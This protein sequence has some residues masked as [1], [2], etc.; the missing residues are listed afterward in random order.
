MRP[1]G[2]VAAAPFGSGGNPGATGEGLKRGNR[3]TPSGSV[4]IS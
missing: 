1:E 4:A 3:A 2:R